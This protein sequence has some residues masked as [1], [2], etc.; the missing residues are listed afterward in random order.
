[1]AQVAYEVPLDATPQSFTV[2][3]AGTEYRMTVKWNTAAECWVMDLSTTAGVS[4]LGGV[5][6]VTG[7]DLLAQYEY[8]NFGCQLVVQTDDDTDAVPTFDNLG[9]NGHLFILVQE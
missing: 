9:T 3:L 5:P 4:V 6:L 8:L 2:S 1:M 7:A